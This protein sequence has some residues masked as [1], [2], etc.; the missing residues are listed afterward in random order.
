MKKHFIIFALAVLTLA[1]CDEDKNSWP[2]LVQEENSNISQRRIPQQQLKETMQ[3]Q[4]TQLQ[5]GLNEVDTSPNLKYNLSRVSMGIDIQTRI[6]ISPLFSAG[7]SRGFELGFEK[8]YVQNNFSK[9]LTSLSKIE[10][11]DVPADWY[12][13]P[14]EM[15]M[16]AASNLKSADWTTAIEKYNT[17]M[18][19][20][21]EG[22]QANHWLWKDHTASVGISQGSIIGLFPV[23]GN[24][25]FR[26]LYER[27][28]FVPAVKSQDK[29][30]PSA[31]IYTVSA[32]ST[33]AVEK[34]FQQ[35]M[36]RVKVKK[37]QELKK[38]LFLQYQEFKSISEQL[39]SLPE[40][41]PWKVK[42]WSWERSLNADGKILPVAS[43][44]TFRY[45]WTWQ[46]RSTNT[47]SPR[48]PLMDFITDL[49]Y[50]LSRMNLDISNDFA[51]SGVKVALSWTSNKLYGLL[52][53]GIGAGL[54]LQFIPTFGGEPPQWTP[55]VSDKA[56]PIF[57]P[58]HANK[59]AKKVNRASLLKGIA[60]AI[61]IGHKVSAT[62][63]RESKKWQ[64]SQLE[65]DYRMG[66]D[67]M[68]KFSLFNSNSA[69]TVTYKR[70]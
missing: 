43:N 57:N 52:P 36:G 11:F 56:I 14:E 25:A 5:S 33:D 41:L 58:D 46:T 9:N 26:A 63:P 13:R 6:A 37:P 69:M 64:L 18:D 48:T 62:M 21:T 38:N 32:Q 60:W 29:A 35:I 39:S 34:L 45:S 53:G 23:S 4:L 51:V 10:E 27:K 16:K 50:D 40:N 68:F 1:S 30:S 28:G 42:S 70:K 15:T 2:L 8:G 55:P 3:N 59:V 31:E 7:R 20:V 17:M 44:A 47:T 12:L 67:G 61:G 49:S 24:A 22:S 19:E 54:E 65:V 66:L